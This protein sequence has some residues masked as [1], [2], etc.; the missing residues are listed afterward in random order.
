MNQ[1]LSGTGLFNYAEIYY[2]SNLIEVVDNIEFRLD[3]VSQVPEPTSLALLGLG[4]AGIGF[5]RKRK[6]V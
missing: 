1:T 6:P 2:D 3:G 4:L 5:S